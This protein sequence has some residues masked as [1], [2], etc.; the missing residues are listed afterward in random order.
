MV[1]SQS[2]ICQAFYQKW[3]KKYK[4]QILKRIERER[5]Y[6]IVADR[7][8]KKYIPKRCIRIWKEF[9]KSQK[10]QK[11]REFRKEMLRASVKVCVVF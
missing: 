11:W 6:N 3:M 1:L 7:F 8:A 2:L 10:D 9:V 4:N 5:S